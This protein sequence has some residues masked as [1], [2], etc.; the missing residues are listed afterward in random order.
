MPNVHHRNGLPRPGRMR[1]AMISAASG[2]ASHGDRKGRSLSHRLMWRASW[3]C[4]GL[5]SLVLAASACYSPS[6]DTCTI[7]CSQTNQCPSG[8]TCN[9][10]QICVGPN[11]ACNSEPRPTDAPSVDGTTQSRCVGTASAC[12]TFRVDSLCATQQGCRFA[13][14]CDNTFVCANQI[15]LCNRYLNCRLVQENDAVFCVRRDDFCVGTT[16]S[17]CEAEHGCTFRTGCTGTPTA[18]QTFA[19]EATCRA[20]GGCAWH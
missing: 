9:A 7:R 15:N 18:C 20:Q 11:Q 3:M 6:L 8:L 5:A 14:A 13:V 12:S 4:R 2:H 10:A 17:R 16:Q 1:M 19:S